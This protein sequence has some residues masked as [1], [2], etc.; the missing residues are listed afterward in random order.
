VVTAPDRLPVTA[1]E[2]EA[3]AAA[4]ALERVGRLD[5]A[6]DA[7]RAVV[8]RWP[9]SFGG[10]MGLG[11]TRFARHDY[12]GARGAF[13]RA[14]HLR[15]EAAEAWNNLAYALARL[16]DRKAAIEAAES[17]VKLGGDNP[18]YRDTLDE[19]RRDTAI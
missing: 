2:P 11:N 7:W 9:A 15:P 13:R 1:G 6:A 18:A 14:I 3:M 19:I 5:E 10:H 16:G 12:A 8:N 17:A 4:A